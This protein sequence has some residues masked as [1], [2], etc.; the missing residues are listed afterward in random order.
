MRAATAIVASSSAT[1]TRSA[2][3]RRSTSALPCSATRPVRSDSGLGWSE[4]VGTLSATPASGRCAYAPT[5]ARRRSVWTRP[6]FTFG[7]RT[8]SMGDSWLC[9]PASRRVCYYRVTFDCP[10]TPP[11]KA[12]RV[13]P[14]P[15][16]SKRTIRNV[17]PLGP[18]GHATD[19]PWRVARLSGALQERPSPR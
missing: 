7:N 4:G 6:S 19:Q 13:P 16:P 14:S 9:G 11:P 2:P 5:R 12:K 10:T 15:P 18:V 3:W 8:I 17:L 1:P